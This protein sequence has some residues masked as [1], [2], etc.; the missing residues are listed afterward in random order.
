MIAQEFQCFCA[1]TQVVLST[2]DNAPTDTTYRRQLVHHTVDGTG[3]QLIDHADTTSPSI[4]R[5]D[6]LKVIDLF[7]KW[8]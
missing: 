4:R 6:R 3:K 2:S 8:N 7:M 5:I 1:Y